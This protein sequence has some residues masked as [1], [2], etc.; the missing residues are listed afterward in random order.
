VEIKGPGVFKGYWKLPEKTK[1]E[2]TED[3]F[4]QTGDV[5]EIDSKGR[6]FML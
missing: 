6:R 4:F 3:G 1:S 2:F 5:G